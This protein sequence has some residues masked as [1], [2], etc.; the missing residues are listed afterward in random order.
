MSRDKIHS[1]VRLDDEVDEDDIETLPSERDRRE[2]PQALRRS[3][4]I[5]GD[6]VASNFSFEI[7]DPGVGSIRFEELTRVFCLSSATRLLIRCTAVPEGY[8]Q[9]TPGRSAL[10]SPTGAGAR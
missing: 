10:I 7:F 8:E 3:L 1:L 6:T 9:P 5:R 2:P 4:Q